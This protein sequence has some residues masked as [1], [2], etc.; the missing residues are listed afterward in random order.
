MKEHKTILKGLKLRSKLLSVN[1]FQCSA[2]CGK[3][4]QSRRVFCGLFD[5][6]GVTKVDDDRCDPSTKYNETKECEIPK[7]KC[8]AKWFAGPWSEVSCNLIF[9]FSS[10]Q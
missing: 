9:G 6:V 4:I 3:G 10:Y 7:E 8:P 5:G 2:K 1:F